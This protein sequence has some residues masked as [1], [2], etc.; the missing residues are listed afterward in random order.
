MLART[1]AVVPCVQNGWLLKL[2]CATSE[3]E[4][5]R[6]RLWQRKNSLAEPI[7]L[8]N[9]NIKSV[10]QLDANKFNNENSDIRGERDAIDGRKKKP[11]SYLVVEVKSYKMVSPCW[12]A[13]FQRENLPLGR[14]EIRDS[15]IAL[16]LESRPDTSRMSR[17]PRCL[18]RA[19]RRG[20]DKESAC[21]RACRSE[22]AFWS[23]LIVLGYRRTIRTDE[24]TLIAM[25]PSSR[26]EH[27]TRSIRGNI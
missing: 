6:E 27:Q 14:A 24:F 13:A 18:E 10:S 11:L 23:L 3:R 8:I 12:T 1:P 15:R 26:D 20:R 9:I 19:R 2:V 17:A 4:R 21:V 7:G 25:F 16:L 5:K 22:P